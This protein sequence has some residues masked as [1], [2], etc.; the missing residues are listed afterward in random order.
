MLDNSWIQKEALVQSRSVRVAVCVCVWLCENVCVEL[1][2]YGNKNRQK[3]GPNQIFFF[4]IHIKFAT[5]MFDWVCALFSIFLI[6][7][8]QYK[9]CFNWSQLNEANRLILIQ[10]K[11]LIDKKNKWKSR[12]KRRVQIRSFSS[13]HW[14][15]T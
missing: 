3:T 12:V 15:V 4:L 7:L 14:S 13:V 10:K 5:L 1:F 9:I 6:S 8:C 11:K 2:Y